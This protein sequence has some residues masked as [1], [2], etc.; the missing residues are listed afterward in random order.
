MH[1]CVSLK[2]FSKKRKMSR[3]FG[4]N[5]SFVFCGIKYSTNSF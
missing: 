1:A 4:G 3:F 5:I 2:K